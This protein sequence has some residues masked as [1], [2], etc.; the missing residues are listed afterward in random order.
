ME[1][2]VDN[3]GAV[4]KSTGQFSTD[5]DL[6]TRLEGLFEQVLTQANFAAQDASFFASVW[7][8]IQSLIKVKRF[9]LKHHFHFHVESM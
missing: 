7:Q 9:K 3:L 6:R 2:V 8:E 1:L 4:I 5:F